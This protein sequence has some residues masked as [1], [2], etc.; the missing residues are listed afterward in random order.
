MRSDDWIRDFPPLG[1]TTQPG[2]MSTRNG[3]G[4][5][6]MGDT[7]TPNQVD[8]HERRS[9]QKSTVR[10]PSSYDRVSAMS[11]PHPT[12]SVPH[13]ALNS[14]ESSKHTYSD[15]DAAAAAKE[16]REME[17]QYLRARAAF[18][19]EESKNAQASLRMKNEGPMEIHQSCSEPSH[20]PA[21][22]CYRTCSS[23]L[24]SKEGQESVT[25]IL[26][27]HQ[28]IDPPQ[29]VAVSEPPCETDT[30]EAVYDVSGNIFQGPRHLLESPPSD[31]AG[32][33]LWCEERVSWGLRLPRREDGSI[34]LI[35][36]G[37]TDPRYEDA[38]RGW[39]ATKLYGWQASSSRV[40]MITHGVPLPKM[41]TDYGNDLGA[42]KPHGT[43]HFP[44]GIP[45]RRDYAGNVVA[46]QQQRASTHEAFASFSGCGRYLD[47]LANM[48]PS[49]EEG[50]RVGETVTPAVRNI[51]SPEQG[52][53]ESKGKE[54]L[55]SRLNNSYSPN[56]SPEPIPQATP[57]I[58]RTALLVTLGETKARAPISFGDEYSSRTATSSSTT[59]RTS[60]AN[61]EAAA[62]ETSTSAIAIPQN[63]TIE[64]R[65]QPNSKPTTPIALKCP[66]SPSTDVESL[67]LGSPLLPFSHLPDAFD[68]SKDNGSG[69]KGSS[70]NATP[71]TTTELPGIQK[72]KAADDFSTPATSSNHP[73]PQAMADGSSLDQNNLDN[74]SNPLAQPFSPD[75]RNNPVPPNTPACEPV[76]TSIP[77]KIPASSK[78]SSIKATANTANEVPSTEPTNT[79]PA[80]LSTYAPPNSPDLEYLTPRVLIDGSD[81][82]SSG[83]SSV[84]ARSSEDEDGFTVVDKKS[85]VEKRVEGEELPGW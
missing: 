25:P 12:D 74:P 13:S 50:S 59:E 28:T 73:P 10:L 22:L 5:M 79:T 7:R 80:I 54:T 83:G 9:E 49:N 15:F 38:I 36:P 46:V 78:G 51:Q 26:Q 70:V 63:P 34:D 64:H 57:S 3:D 61:K 32:A 39:E 40:D 55:T 29:D 52:S 11:H 47:M 62:R 65:K 24:A 31:S 27:P 35:I 82:S 81:G 19:A 30:T 4:Y 71:N 14:D 43:P 76:S 48:A 69:S 17:F 45:L 85:G 60:T 72:G 68:L 16:R 42:A 53:E 77:S 75:M 44:P 41:Q 18:E 20:G 33:I 21:C 23:D 67:L 37:Y 1:E 2:D 8:P 6:A 84:G 66:N 58:Q 56:M